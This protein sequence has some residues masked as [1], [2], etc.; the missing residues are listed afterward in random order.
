MFIQRECI[1]CGSYLWFWQYNDN[2]IIMPLQW[3]NGHLVDATGRLV[4]YFCLASV[5][6][7]IMGSKILF[8]ESGEVVWVDQVGLH[9]VC[10]L[11]SLITTFLDTSVWFSDFVSLWEDKGVG[12]FSVPFSD[13]VRAS[14]M[15]SWEWK[16]IT[17]LESPLDGYHQSLVIT[18]IP[19]WSS[20][21]HEIVEFW[22]KNMTIRMRIYMSQRC[23]YKDNKKGDNILLLHGRCKLKLWKHFPIS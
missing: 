3:D 5:L 18:R 10:D 12:P 20:L 11:C 4:S 23:K 19:A 6:R 22:K 21:L 13:C 2:F 14:S 8:M 7:E 16:S 15:T 1:P 17:D 9:R